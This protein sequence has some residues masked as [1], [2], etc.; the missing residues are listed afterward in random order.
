MITEIKLPLQRYPCGGQDI[1][2]EVFTITIEQKLWWTTEYIVRLR[3]GDDL[4]AINKRKI[5]CEKTFKSQIMRHD[6]HHTWLHGKR[7]HAVQKEVVNSGE[8][9]DFLKKAE[10][11]IEKYIRKNFPIVTWEVRPAATGGYQF[12]PYKVKTNNIIKE[13]M[14]R[15]DAFGNST[16]EIL[17]TKGTAIATN[18]KGDFCRYSW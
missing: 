5:I 12:A 15:H 2:Q 8:L 18:D 11:Y 17:S 3:L 9:D 7:L 4:A 14:S 10:R 16:R 13:L 1:L 6:L